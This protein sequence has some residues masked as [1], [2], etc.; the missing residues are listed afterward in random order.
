MGS[1]GPRLTEKERRQNHIRSENK[2]REAIRAQY[3]ILA[4]IVP[5]MQ[6]SS[7]SE[8]PLLNA[9]ASHIRDLILE[10]E[11]LIA[12]GKARGI[13]TEGWELPEDIVEEAKRQEANK[14]KDEESQKMKG[15]TE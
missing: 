6:G 4:N 15:E 5:G 3:E 2:R 13:N 14:G 11:S 12:Q 8:A 9:T 1:P 7:R 10:R